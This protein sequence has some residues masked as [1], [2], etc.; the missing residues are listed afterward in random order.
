[1]HQPFAQQLPR[2]EDRIPVVKRARQLLHFS[3]LRG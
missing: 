3:L 2:Y 1:M